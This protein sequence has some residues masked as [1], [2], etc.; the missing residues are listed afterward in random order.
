M[1]LVFDNFPNLSDAEKFV[2]DVRCRFGL[3]GEAFAS[4]ESGNDY[5]AQRR[6]GEPTI[7]EPKNVPFVYIDRAEITYHIDDRGNYV[8]DEPEQ[9]EAEVDRA[10]DTVWRTVRRHVNLLRVADT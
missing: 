7:A 3:C 4:V 6:W 5:L 8:I 10:R 2:G 1:C 9:I